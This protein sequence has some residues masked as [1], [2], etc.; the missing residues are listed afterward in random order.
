MRTLGQILIGVILGA[1]VGGGGMWTYQ[2]YSDYRREQQQLAQQEAEQRQA[3]KDSLL[4][5]RAQQDEKYQQEERVEA[6]QKVMC[7]CL[8]SFYREEVLGDRAPSLKPF[9][10]D[11]CHATR[12]DFLPPHLKRMTKDDRRSLDRRLRVAHDHDDWYRVHLVINGAT[13]YRYLR[14]SRR[15]DDIIIYAVR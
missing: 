10:D 15:A 9:L 11:S 14:A 2:K 1:I 6:E 5:V 13:T 12:D 3:H 8:A 7:E 4:R